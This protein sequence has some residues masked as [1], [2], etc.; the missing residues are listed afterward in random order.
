M[1]NP[2]KIGSP[3]RCHGTDTS[4]TV[5]PA[6]AQLVQPSLDSFVDPCHGFVAVEPLPNDANRQFVGV[7]GPRHGVGVVL[8]RDR[9]LPGIDRILPGDSLENEGGVP[10][11]P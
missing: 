4:S 3:S 9:A 2:R 10:R 7:G 6:S 8:G 1:A 5:A 11:S